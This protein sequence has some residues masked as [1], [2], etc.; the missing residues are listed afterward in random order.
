MIVHVFLTVRS[1][2]YAHS[3]VTK[4]VLYLFFSKYPN[5]T[6]TQVINVDHARYI[7]IKAC[8]NDTKI[9]KISV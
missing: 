8:R 7:Y 6:F 5:A 4:P 1:N 2:S 9:K 3:L